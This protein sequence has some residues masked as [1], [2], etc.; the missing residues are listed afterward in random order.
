MTA[1]KTPEIAPAMSVIAMN[2][3]AFNFVPSL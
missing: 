2:V 1:R 3:I